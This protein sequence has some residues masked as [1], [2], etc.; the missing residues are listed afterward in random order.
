MST[1]TYLNLDSKTPREVAI[2]TL[3][4]LHKQGVRSI[5]ENDKCSYL[6]TD[7]NGNTLK[8]AVGYWIDKEDYN[9]D[10]EGSTCNNTIFNNLLPSKHIPVLR[11]LQIIHDFS[12][13][14]NTKKLIELVGPINPEEYES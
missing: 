13:A 2:E 1:K 7:E 3:K 10:L 14:L 11:E 5:N 12:Y 4:H 6:T 9:P 8:C